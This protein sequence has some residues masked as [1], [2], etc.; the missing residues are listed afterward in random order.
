VR[1]VM[2]RMEGTPETGEAAQGGPGFGGDGASSDLAR[3]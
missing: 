2:A 3:T 1:A